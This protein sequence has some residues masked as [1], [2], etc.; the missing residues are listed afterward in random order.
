MEH[1]SEAAV[2]L[3]TPIPLFAATGLAAS[4]V[5][6]GEHATWMERAPHKRLML[7]AGRSNIALG[8]AIAERLGIQL[9]D[10]TL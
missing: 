2:S 8:Q 6:K 3:E 7:F 5:T 1:E 9:G 4:A 10:V